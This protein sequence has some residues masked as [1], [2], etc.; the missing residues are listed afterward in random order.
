MISP[1]CNNN[2]LA[3][4]D[5]VFDHLSLIYAKSQKPVDQNDYKLMN[6]DQIVI[7]WC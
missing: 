2:M 3:A 5:F 7:K 6:I 1:T 4:S